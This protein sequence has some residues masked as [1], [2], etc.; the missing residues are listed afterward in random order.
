MTSSEC[1]IYGPPMS[2]PPHLL[3]QQPGP[4]FG[5]IYGSQMQGAAACIQELKKLKYV[6]CQFGRFSLIKFD[7]KTIKINILSLT[8][9]HS[10]LLPS[11]WTTLI[12]E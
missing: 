1:Q 10:G 4:P 7:Y 11:P 6:V 12:E 3:S 9:K 5:S 8:K 2:G